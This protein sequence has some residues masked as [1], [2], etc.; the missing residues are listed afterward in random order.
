MQ[1]SMI[2]ADILQFGCVGGSEVGC[3]WVRGRAATLLNIRWND[4]W[5][6]D[7]CCFIIEVF[8][9]NKKEIYNNNQ[10]STILNKD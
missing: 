3:E 8:M 7:L 5:Y 4:E 1:N 2:A 9:Y 10:A 6:Q